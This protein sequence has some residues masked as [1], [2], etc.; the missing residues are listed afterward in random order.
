MSDGVEGFGLKVDCDRD[1]SR[2][3]RELYPR[4]GEGNSGKLSLSTRSPGSRT[5][6]ILGSDD[7]LLIVDEL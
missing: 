1:R 3:K 6:G 2:P 4:A 5:S 7:V